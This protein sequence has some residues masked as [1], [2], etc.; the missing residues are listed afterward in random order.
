MKNKILGSILIT[1]ILIIDLFANVTAKI[2]VPAIY[3]GEIVEFS[4]SAE[5]NDV[6]FPT[7]DEI[8]SYPILGT[9]SSQSTTIINSKVTR[10]ISK[11][12]TFAPLKDVT[13]PSYEVIVDGKRYK[14]KEL[15]VAVLKP[16]ASQKG[17]D[18]VVSMSVDKKSATVGESIKLT[19]S[20]K[21]K[22]NAHADKLQIS[23]PRL[24]DFWIKK[25]EGVQKSTKGEYIIQQISYILF[26][27]KSGKYKLAPIE[28][29]IGKLVRNRLGSSDPFF[30][31]PFFDSF[32]SQIKWQKI[33]SNEID[34]DIKPLPNGV[35]LF[36][37]FS[38]KA[39]VD[40][41][42][43]SANKPVNLT[44]NIKG[45]GNIDD[46]K[47]FDLDIDEAIVY[48]DE[49]K[50]V[51]NLQN[52]VYKGE[53]TQKIAIIAEN[54]FT[55]PPIKLKYLDKKTKQIKIIQTKPIQIKV[56]GAK[57]AKKPSIES[58]N[59]NTP[60]IETK[61]DNV[62]VEE[63]NHIKYLFL[64]AGLLFGG[65]IGYIGRGLKFEKTKKELD[66]VK[67]IKKTKDDKELFELLLPYAKKDKLISTTLDKLEQNIYKFQNHKIDKLKLIEFF[68]ELEE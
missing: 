57:K 53:F 4:I 42:E 11:T 14:T 1:F 10:S 55:I 25:V 35:E 19:I 5:G 20:F 24:E 2:N 7:I 26:P 37:D 60:T 56:K 63:S 50:I 22:L 39:S 54:D 27:Q 48:A 23:E 62:N 52:G 67:K 61:N 64:L 21:Q 43:V 33:F 34:L 68:E 17:A 51:T 40:K 9:S 15:K 65:M 6:V 44:I 8:D 13:I 49:P 31:D 46:I 45:E 58:L 59:D 30:N 29:D 36:G 32:T 18:F 3:K 38:I 47:K 66:I 28:A 41:Y 16:T 12:Y